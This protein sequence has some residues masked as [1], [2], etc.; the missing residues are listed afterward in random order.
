MAKLGG[1]ILGG[2]GGGANLKGKD[3]VGGEEGI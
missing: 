2:G 1:L 3:E